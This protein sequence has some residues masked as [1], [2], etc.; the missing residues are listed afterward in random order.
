MRKQRFL[1]RDYYIFEINRV[2]RIKWLALWRENEDGVS[3]EAPCF[4]RA[5]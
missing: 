1:Y 2:V 3:F 5:T 4:Y